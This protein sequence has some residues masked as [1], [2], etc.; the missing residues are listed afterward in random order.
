[1]SLK[2]TSA[3]RSSAQCDEAVAAAEIEERRRGTDLACI[4]H[5]IAQV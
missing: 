3:P 2:I 5:S 4:E 1:M